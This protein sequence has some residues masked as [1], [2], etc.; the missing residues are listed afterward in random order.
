ME[1]AGRVYSKLFNRT[2]KSI[3]DILKEERENSPRLE[4]EQ[5]IRLKTIGYCNSKGHA[6]VCCNIIKK[7]FITDVFVKLEMQKNGCSDL[8]IITNRNVFFVDVIAPGFDL[9][10]KQ[11]EFK[12]LIESLNKHYVVVR[13]VEDVMVI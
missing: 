6:I 3:D 5:E 1:E 10:K 12:K 4:I 13:S 2:C 11:K 8:I 7:R 9:S